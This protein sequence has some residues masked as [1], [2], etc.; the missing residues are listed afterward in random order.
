MSKKRDG[1]PEEVDEYL[2]GEFEKGKT[3]LGGSLS[4]V[5]RTQPDEVEGAPWKKKKD[6]EK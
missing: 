1:T 6:E 5:L 3:S 2:M 4:S